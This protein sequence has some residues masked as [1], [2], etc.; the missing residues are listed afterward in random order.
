MKLS[1]AE[2]K[3]IKQE[4]HTE[5]LKELGVEKVKTYFHNLPVI[6]NIFTAC[7]FL[8]KNNDILSRGVSICSPLDTFKRSE[9]RKRAY[10]R[11]MRALHTKTDSFPINS[12][13]LRFGLEILRRDFKLR[14]EEDEKVMFDQIVPV[15]NMVAGD[16]CDVAINTIQRKKKTEDGSHKVVEQKTA[17]Y[18]LP[19][20]I[21]LY[22]TSEK[23]KCKSCYKP[24]P[25]NDEL[26][27]I[28]PTIEV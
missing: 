3:K 7:L 2:K 20:D 4:L 9:G 27:I 10:K 16:Y 14:T 25:T 28:K 15:L 6:G 21:T 11:A 12:Y 8:D 17:T 24:E 18:D 19:R 26:N 1:K 23:F 5:R 22:L 13:M